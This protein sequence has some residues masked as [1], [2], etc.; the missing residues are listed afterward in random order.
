MIWWLAGLV[1]AVALALA[2]RRTSSAATAD[3]SRIDK[4]RSAGGPYESDPDAPYGRRWKM[5][6]PPGLPASARVASKAGLAAGPIREI[7]AALG[8]SGAFT[9]TVLALGRNESNLT[10]GLPA[11]TFDARPPEQRGGRPLITAWGVFQYN[12]G[13]WRAEVSGNGEPWE[14]TVRAEVE[15]P[16]LVYKRIWDRAKAAGAPNEYAER[17][18]RLWHMAPAVVNAFIRDGGASGNWPA[19]WRRVTF[20]TIS[21]RVARDVIDSKLRA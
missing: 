3:G 14:A 4:P 1:G 15:V 7:S 10:L 2:A 13:A 8:M 11:S 19:A 12:R 21:G 9:E 5:R 6:R 20:V 18:V 16:I 17:A